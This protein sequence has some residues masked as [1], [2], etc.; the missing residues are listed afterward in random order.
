[1]NLS[2]KKMTE[3]WGAKIKQLT[4]YRE[5]TMDKFDKLEEAI[6][7]NMEP[8]AA[9]STLDEI[10]HKYNLMKEYIDEVTD[11]SSIVYSEI[12]LKGKKLIDNE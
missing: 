7:N 9:L 11:H 5:I 6:R 4:Y 3:D 10:R 8:Y 1:M 12:A 2:L